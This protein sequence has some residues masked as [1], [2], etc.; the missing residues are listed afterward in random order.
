MKAVEHTF[1]EF[2]D[3]IQTAN[4]ADAFER[5][6]TRLAQSLG[7]QRF[8]YLRLA[9]ETPTLISSY[10]KSWTSR[11]LNLGYQLLDPVVH[12]A[13]LEHALFSWGGC[14]SFPS[15]N[16][17]QRRFFDEATTFGISPTCAVGG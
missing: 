4:T 6:G 3:A 17:E 7:F 8:A 5:V 10:P 15:V 9:G 1:Q 12:R 13:R 14:A 2:I 11:Y 16:R